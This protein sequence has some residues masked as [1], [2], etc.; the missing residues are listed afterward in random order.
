M[1]KTLIALA[2]VAA[3]GAALAQSSVTMYGRIDAG[4]N[5]Q[6]TTVTTPAGVST[7]TKGNSLVGDSGL[8]TSLIGIR[9]SEDLGG[10]LKANFVAEW[11]YATSGGAFATAGPGRDNTIGLSGGFGD[12]RMGR[13][14]TP[15][16]SVIGMSDVFATTGATTVSNFPDGVRA[17]SAWFYTTPNMGGFTARVM[18]GDADAGTNATVA[19]GRQYGLYGMYAAGPLAV[20]LGYGNIKGV[21]GPIAT[22]T[23]GKT[24]GS[25]LSATYDLGAA[26]LFFGHNRGKTQGNVTVANYTKAAETNFGVSVPM[27]AVTLMAAYGRNNN[28]D[29]TAGVAEKRSGNDFVVGATYALSKRTTAYFKTGT[30]N[31]WK[32]GTTLP[33]TK[34]N[35]TSVGLRHVF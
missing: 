1:K 30:Y 16:F 8:S 31:K 6:K 15:L 19:K 35:R 5:N 9:G 18:L 17:S 33:G 24:T 21:A 29:V 10:G 4:L 7:Y 28:S 13:S 34:T 22:P 14:Y 11:N 20:G 32:A 2:A 3:T 26:K 12:F 27:G 25:A 23:T